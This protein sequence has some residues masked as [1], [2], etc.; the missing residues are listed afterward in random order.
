MDRSS[1]HG[2]DPNAAVFER[3]NL[4][5]LEILEDLIVYRFFFR[6]AHPRGC[7][8]ILLFP[9]N[10]SYRGYPVS[11]GNLARAARVFLLIRS[12]GVP[13]KPM[14]NAVGGASSKCR[15]LFFEPLT[16][17]L[18]GPAVLGDRAHDVVRGTAWDLRLDLERHRHR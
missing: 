7:V 3:E 1:G 6:M 10:S 18:Q 11:L 12:M 8:F 9:R 13:V 5:T 2:L 14:N 4:T 16:L 15:L 17:E